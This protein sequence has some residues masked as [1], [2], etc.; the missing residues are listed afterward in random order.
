MNAAGVEI[1]RSKKLQGDIWS[2]TVAATRLPKEDP[3]GARLLLPAITDMIRT[4]RIG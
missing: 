2:A 4:T 3:T 1:A